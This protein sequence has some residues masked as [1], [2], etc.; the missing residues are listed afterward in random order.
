MPTWRDAAVLYG[1]ALTL[2]LIMGALGAPSAA[3]LTAGVGWALGWMLWR[4]P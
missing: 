3:G 2:G 1:G 4:R